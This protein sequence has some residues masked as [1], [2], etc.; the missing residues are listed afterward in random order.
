[1]TIPHPTSGDH[2][3]IYEILIDEIEISKFNVRK[4]TVEKDLQE[5]AAS[6][7]EHGQ[8]QPVVLR[9]EYGKPPYELII[10][11]RRYCALR[12][13]LKA[14][15][16]KATF[17]GYISPLNAKIR[18]LAENMVR[19]ELS[20]EDTADAVTA[21]YKE[22]G[23]NDQKVSEKTGL[24]LRKVRQFIYIEERASEKT[25]KELRDG[26]VQP[27]DVQR[28]LRAASDDIAKA[29]RLLELMKKHHLDR[30]QKSRLVDV[31]LA[32][33]KAS[34]EKIIELAKPPAIEKVYMVRLPEKVHAA[35]L[36][37]SK[38]L[39]HTPDELAAQA[40]EEWLKEKGFLE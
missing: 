11:Q 40:V 34:P 33:P 24:S 27:A 21:L 14:E 9:G 26:K 8:L 17:A 13:I 29:D 35:L 7:K 23:R 36:T 15:T 1:M 10:G 39:A 5:L 6:I 12:D 30:Y 2:H 31:G 37:A 28:A 16:I 4:H 25:R 3:I 20:Y 19:S 38:S 18:S 22:L 32:N